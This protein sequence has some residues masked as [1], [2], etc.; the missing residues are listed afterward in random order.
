MLEWE[1]ELG[2]V[3]LLRLWWR[4]AVIVTDPAAVN[5]LLKR[6]L[7]G[8]KFAEVGAFNMVRSPPLAKPG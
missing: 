4:R 2:P 8:S 1:K 6:S 5:S 7:D 3:M